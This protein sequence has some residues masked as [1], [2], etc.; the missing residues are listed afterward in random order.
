LPFEAAAAPEEYMRVL[1]PVLF[2]RVVFEQAVPTAALP[3]E[4]PTAPAPI[5][6]PMC[7]AAWARL[8][9]VPPPSVQQ[10][11][12]MAR[13]NV[14]ITHILPATNLRCDASKLRFSINTDWTPESLACVAAREH[15][16][17]SLQNAIAHCLMPVALID[18][19]SPM[20]SFQN[21]GNFQSHTIFRDF[22]VLDLAF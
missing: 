6:E 11:T 12:T 22:A 14:D 13:R 17:G 7:V 1:A 18:D 9:L 8:P 10:D 2:T 5:E 20:Q 16:I 19:P 4:E 21:E 3:I 15:S